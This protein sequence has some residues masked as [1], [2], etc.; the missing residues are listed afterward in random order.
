MSAYDITRFLRHAYRPFAYCVPPKHSLNTAY[1][2]GGG[3]T[4]IINKN[5]TKHMLK[6]TYYITV[7]TQ[8]SLPISPPQPPSPVDKVT[9][10]LMCHITV[11]KVVISGYLKGNLIKDRKCLFCYFVNISFTYCYMMSFLFGIWLLGR[12]RS[13]CSSRCLLKT[14]YGNTSHYFSCIWFT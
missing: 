14:G 6:R 5:M 12:Y 3:V 10:S 7:T 2:K 11:P 9:P 13:R 4:L 1:Q 8:H